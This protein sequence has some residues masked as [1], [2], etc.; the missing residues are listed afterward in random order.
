M[1]RTGYRSIDAPVKDPKKHSVTFNADFLLPD[2][3]TRSHGQ[4]KDNGSW[5]AQFH[6]VAMNPTC[7]I[8]HSPHIQ[9]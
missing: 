7:T 8:V 1:K 5:S 6:T 4:T 2:S 9:L 3:P